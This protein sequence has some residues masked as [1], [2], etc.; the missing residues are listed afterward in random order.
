[1]NF[2]F[3]F[4]NE[5]DLGVVLDEKVFNVHFIGHPVQRFDKLDNPGCLLLVS[6]QSFSEVLFRLGVMFN[7]QFAYLAH[8]LLDLGA[9]VIF[10]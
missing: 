9:R 5:H 6:W 1:L 4:F 3:G 10:V 7:R 8:E 2:F